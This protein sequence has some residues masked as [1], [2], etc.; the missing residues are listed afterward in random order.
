M[1]LEAE[2]A[3]SVGSALRLSKAELR[4]ITRFERGQGLLAANSNHAMIEVRASR[5]EN[6]LITTDRAEL[7]R[8]AKEKLQEREAGKQHANP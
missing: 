7:E 5:H 4:E 6:D 2:E 1:K 3:K 8:I